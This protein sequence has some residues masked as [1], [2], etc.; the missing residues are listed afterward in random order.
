MPY[1][2]VQVFQIEAPPGSY[3]PPTLITGVGTASR[4][5]MDAIF[6]PVLVALPFRWVVVNDS[7]LPSSPVFFISAGYA[8]SVGAIAIFSLM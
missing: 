3:Y 6:G 8:I 5:V 2:V 4:C 7:L 1:T